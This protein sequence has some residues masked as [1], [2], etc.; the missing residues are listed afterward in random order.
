[1]W[2]AIDPGETT[3]YAIFDDVGELVTNGAIKGHD[4]FLDWL[5]ERT[6]VFDGCIL[7]DYQVR[8]QQFNH[9]GSRVPTIQ[10]IGAIKRWARKRSIPV[11]LQRSD[12]LPVACKFIGFP[13][14]RGIHVPDH[15]SAL[16]HGVYWLQQHKIRKHQLVRKTTPPDSTTTQPNS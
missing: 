2:I 3:G 8:N 14:K 16:A 12:V 10:L 1:M 15:I 7:E 13:Y 4:T 6:D 9:Q 11:H 5:D